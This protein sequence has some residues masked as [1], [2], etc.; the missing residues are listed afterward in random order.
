MLE[1]R[2]RLACVI[3]RP[4]AAE[5]LIRCGRV[6]LCDIALAAS[7][8]SPLR[9]AEHFCALR[10]EIGLSHEVD[11]AVRACCVFLAPELLLNSRRRRRRSGGGSGRSRS[12]S[13]VHLLAYSLLRLLGPRCGV[14][15]ATRGSFRGDRCGALHRRSRFAPVHTPSTWRILGRARRPGARPVTLIATATSSQ[16]QLRRTVAARPFV[17]HV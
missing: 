3:A 8:C 14:N 1:F 15:G 17:V 16:A 11:T 13:G 4:H 7:L 10:A 9:G 5:E 12:G 2:V 6:L